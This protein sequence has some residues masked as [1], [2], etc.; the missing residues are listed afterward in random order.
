MGGRS[1]NSKNASNIQ[2][3]H[4]NG[5]AHDLLYERSQDKYFVPKKGAILGEGDSGIQGP[6]IILVKPINAVKAFCQLR[7]FHITSSLQFHFLAL[8]ILIPSS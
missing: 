2:M 5:E 7:P 3:A 4:L 8:L 6:A 1:K